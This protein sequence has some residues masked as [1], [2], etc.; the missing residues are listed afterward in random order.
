M[1]QKQR[2]GPPRHNSATDGATNADLGE[3]GRSAELSRSIRRPTSHDRASVMHSPL[4]WFWHFCDLGGG[5]LPYVCFGPDSV[6]KVE[7]SEDPPVV[8]HDRA[9]RHGGPPRPQSGI[10]FYGPE[11][12]GSS[13]M[14]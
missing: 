5:L 6:E 14:R 11:K 7:N 9:M 2:P 12:A 13:P 10:A 4:V 1:R 8:T 3:D